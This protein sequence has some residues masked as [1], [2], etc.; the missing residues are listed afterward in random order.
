MPVAETDRP[1]GRTELIDSEFV[2]RQRPPESAIQTR[3]WLHLAV[4]SIS[5]TKY[6]IEM[7]AGER[8]QVA[9]HDLVWRANL[10]P[11]SDVGPN[12]ICVDETIIRVDGHR[13]WPYASVESDSNQICHIQPLST[14]T[15]QFTLLFCR[16]TR[17]K[18]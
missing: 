12:Q 7:L 8:S 1:N 2:E 6:C 13:H 3:T 14:Q 18:Q 16:D 5:N 4:L 9:M 10:Q 17:E 15:T 11:D